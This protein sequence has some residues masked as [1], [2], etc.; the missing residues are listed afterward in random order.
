M[1]TKINSNHR[2]SYTGINVRSNAICLS[3]EFC[4]RYVKGNKFASPKWDDAKGI[5]ELTFYPLDSDVSFRIPIMRFGNA[6]RMCCA[7]FSS[8][9]KQFKVG[10]YEVFDIDLDRSGNVILKFQLERN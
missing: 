5:L 1:S 6:Y 10:R 3:K 2:D 9:L 4:D 7:K 8:Q